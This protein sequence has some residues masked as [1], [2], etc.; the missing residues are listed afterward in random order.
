VALGVVAE[1]LNLPRSA[2]H[3]LLNEL[4]H[5]GYLRQPLDHGA[6]ALTTKLVAMGLSF[7]G[8]SGII[9]IAQPIL[10]R[11]AQ[12]SGEF[13]RLSILDGERLTWVARAQ[14]RAPDCVMTRKWAPPPPFPARHRVMPSFRP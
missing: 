12:V 1:R 11:V 13:V 10:D 4:V 3:R 9:D 8:S 2:T 7:L 6:Y 14:D 5:Y